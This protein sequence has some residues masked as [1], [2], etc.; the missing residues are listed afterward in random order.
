MQFG[1]GE[2]LGPAFEDLDK[3]SGVSGGVAAA[4]DHH[5]RRL[6]HVLTDPGAVVARRVPPMK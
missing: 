6:K 1:G 4:V 2:G 3:V 5:V